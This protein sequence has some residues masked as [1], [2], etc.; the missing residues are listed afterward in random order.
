[1][2]DDIRVIL[3][4]LADR[5]HNMRTLQFQPEV[6]QRAIA[7]ET[8]DIYAP[9][10]HRLD[11]HSFWSTFI[12]HALWWGRGVMVFMEDSAG[13]PQA[14]S[15]RL[16]NPYLIGPDKATGNWV[17]DPHGATPIL[18]DRDG[19]FIAGGRIWRLAV[20]RGMSPND[21]ATP[22]GVLTRHYDTLRIGA[23]VS[24][25]VANT[26]SSGVPAGFLKVSTPNFKQ[27]QADELRDNWMKAHR[28]RR[29][30]AILNATVDFNPISISPLD[31]DADKMVRL[32]ES[33]IAHMFNLSS[34]WLDLGSS[35]L[36]YMNNSD[37]RRDLV[38]TSLA[39][40]DN[41]LVSTVSAMLPYGQRMVLDWTSFTAPNLETLAVAIQLLHSTGI[42]TALEARQYLGL[43]TTEGPDP[44][45]RPPEPLSIE[46][47]QS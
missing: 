14:G 6:K 18:T 36:S 2:S 20:L 47:G 45:W 29:S 16:I 25:Y 31:A 46:G 4:K 11:S 9:I 26:F 7:R 23:A 13:N 5:L 35:G 33:D 3:I 17:L 21:G 22:E 40:W 1:M 44:A 37:R 10:A 43:A 15:L 28:G 8:L 34:I 12:T 32:N 30:I 42:L 38:D 19:R 41:R 24:E 39:G 27:D